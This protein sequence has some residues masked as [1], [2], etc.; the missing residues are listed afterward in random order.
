MR[1]SGAAGGG[2][3]GRPPKAK[4]GAVRVFLRGA[5]FGRTEGVRQAFGYMVARAGVRCKVCGG[6]AKSATVGRGPCE[7]SL[8]TERLLAARLAWG[9]LL[10]AD[11]ERRT[12]L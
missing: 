11:R 6:T 4:G 5:G 8:G 3:T 12:V 9:C 10:D 1:L 2:G 7:I